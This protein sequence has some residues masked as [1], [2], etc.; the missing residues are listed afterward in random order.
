MNKITIPTTFIV[1]DRIRDIMYEKIAYR[2]NSL[3]KLSSNKRNKEITLTLKDNVSKKELKEII[4]T[5]NKELSSLSK[6]ERFSKK[7]S[8]SQTIDL[9]ESTYNKVKSIM[10]EYISVIPRI[11][12][13]RTYNNEDGLRSV[14]GD[15]QK[16]KSWLNSLISDIFYEL[17]SPTQINVPDLISTCSVKRSGYFNTSSQ[18]MYFVG[19]VNKDTS[20]FDKYINLTNIGSFDDAFK[21]LKN[22]NMVLNPAV[23]LQLYPLI[24]KKIMDSSK[25][26][27]FDLIGKAFRDEGGKFNFHDRLREFEVHE[28]VFFGTPKQL[29]KLY[30][31]VVS[32]TQMLFNKLN[33]PIE[34]S[35]SNDIFFGPQNDKYLFSQMISDDKLEFTTLHSNISLASINKHKSK[36]TDEYSITADNSEKIHSFC[37]AFG[38]DRIL[39]VYKEMFKEKL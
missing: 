15:L 39:S 29:Q 12:D 1:S 24:E 13:Y 25:I 18:M 20:S 7:R 6:I 33:I 36:F 17:F 21:T 35:F 9:D 37:L 38:I 14:S 19:E 23:C 22:A 26:T 34:S 4:N 28:I 11:N 5:I 32:V 27:T 10:D 8:Y 16:F 31:F 3:Q 2:F 30:P